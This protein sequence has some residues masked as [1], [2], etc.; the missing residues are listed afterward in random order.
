MWETGIGVAVH[1]HFNCSTLAV[2]YG[3]DYYCPNFLMKDDLIKFPLT[4]ENDD[5]F[6]PAGSGLGVDVDW[7]A[8]ERHRVK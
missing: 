4:F 3:S 8:I 5:L 7:N 2:K 1:L 6:V